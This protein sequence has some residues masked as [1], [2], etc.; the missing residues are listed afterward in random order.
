MRG[1]R[2]AG[3][4]VIGSRVKEIELELKRKQMSKDR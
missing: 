2:W 1:G 4:D 3:L